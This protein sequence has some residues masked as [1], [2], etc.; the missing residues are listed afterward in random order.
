MVPNYEAL[1]NRPVQK[2]RHRFRYARRLSLECQA[3]IRCLREYVS[4]V[5]LATAVRPV[6]S[7]A[8]SSRMRRKGR[9]SGPGNAT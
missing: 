6:F 4:F 9:F 8:M 2:Q 1:M 7:H 3:T 5:G